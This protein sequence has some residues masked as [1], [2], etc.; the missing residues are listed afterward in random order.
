MSNMARTAAARLRAEKLEKD[1]LDK[2]RAEKEAKERAV[3]EQQALLKRL[4]EQRR[5]AQRKADELEAK[6]KV[7]CTGGRYI[8]EFKDGPGRVP[9]GYGEFIRQHLGD[10]PGPVLEHETG[11]QARPRRAARP[12]SPPARP[13]CAA[14]GAS[15]ALSAAPPPGADWHAPRAVVPHGARPGADQPLRRHDSNLP[16]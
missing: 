16:C 9:H 6:T 13:C 3:A 2:E 15:T 14:A 10:R 4:E 1:R 8:G 7:Y 11:V 12:C 5:V